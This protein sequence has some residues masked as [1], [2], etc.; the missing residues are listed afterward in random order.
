MVRRS[1]SIKHTPE[2]LQPL[3]EEEEVGQEVGAKTGAALGI[4]FLMLMF[5]VVAHSSNG[6]ALHMLVGV[7][8]AMK[9]FWRMSASYLFLLPFAVRY[10]W[11]EGLPRLSFAGGLALVSASFFYTAQNLLFYTALEH[12]T[13]GDAVIFANSQALLLIVGK[14]FVGERI[15]AFEGLGVV[16]AFGGAILCSFDSEQ[17]SE[18]SAAA[19]DNAVLG[20]VL[21]LCAS[22]LGVA[23]LTVARA[24]R[25]Q[26]SVAFFVTF[27]MFVGSLMAL[28]YLA[29]NPH[30]ELTFDM[31]PYHGV[32][33]GFSST[34][35]R[36]AVMAYLGIV[37]NMAGSCGF[38]NAMK[39]FS[40]VVIAVATLAEPLTASLIAY[41]FRAGLLPGP[42][43]WVGNCLVFIGTLSVV[44][45]SMGRA[46]K[47]MH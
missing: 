34:H 42:M 36:F 28:A 33:G 20:D 35:H 39:T 24:V 47:G 41:A 30:E 6:T 38:I 37:V 45:P 23:Y 43:G 46:D 12:T 10:V 5:A 17:S 27:V 8:P 7:S 9:L 21:A 19:G 2:E 44:Y 3:E 25:S 1:S 11:L 29:V 31:D 13:I 16:V 15:H 22:A 4:N 26:M 40:T 18:A 14:A 32:F